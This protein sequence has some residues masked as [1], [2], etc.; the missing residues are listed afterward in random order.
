MRIHENMVC[1]S[2]GDSANDV[3][4]EPNPEFDTGLKKTIDKVLGMY[5]GTHDFHNFTTKVCSD[6]ITR[7]NAKVKKHIR[8]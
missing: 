2:Q 7:I 5:V 6:C 3:P 8:N 1:L 4:L